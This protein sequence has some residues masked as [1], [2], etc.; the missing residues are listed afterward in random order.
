VLVVPVGVLVVPAPALA[1]APVGIWPRST[2]VPLCEGSFL[3]FAA[4]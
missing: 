2:L 1:A 4:A 3:L